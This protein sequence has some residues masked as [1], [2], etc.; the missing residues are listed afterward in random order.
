MSGV[1]AVTARYIQGYGELLYFDNTC[2]FQRTPHGETL[3]NLTD[4]SEGGF[5]VAPQGNIVNGVITWAGTQIAASGP[6]YAS[7]EDIDGV[8]PKHAGYLAACVRQEYMVDRAKVL[9]TG[10]PR[11]TLYLSLYFAS[12]FVIEADHV[13]ARDEKTWEMVTKPVYTVIDPKIM[14]PQLRGNP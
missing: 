1:N 14:E 2:I 8:L 11:Y 6:V 5:A 7:G 12:G 10:V 3:A 9:L 4:Y 13:Q